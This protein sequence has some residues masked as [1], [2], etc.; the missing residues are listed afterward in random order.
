[1]VV[2]YLPSSVIKT[3]LDSLEDSPEIDDFST[4][5][6]NNENK[7]KEDYIIESQG[8]YS[9]KGHLTNYEK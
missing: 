1:M 2:F 6:I 4:Q 3:A 9:K 7:M 8:S 5:E